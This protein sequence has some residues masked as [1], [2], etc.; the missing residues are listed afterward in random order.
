MKV[1]GY[2]HRERMNDW[3]G[4]HR[5]G[6]STSASILFASVYSVMRFVYVGL[7]DKVMGTGLLEPLR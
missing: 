6:G 2:D 3:N 1:V 4:I 7:D 5:V